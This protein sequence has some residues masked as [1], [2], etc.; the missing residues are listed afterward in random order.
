VIELQ[1]RYENV[2]D[3]VIGRL[4]RSG[5]WTG[6]TRLD[7][8]FMFGALNWSPVVPA[9]RHAR[10]GGDRSRGGERFFLRTPPLRASAAAVRSLQRRRAREARPRQQE[11][12]NDGAAV[13][14]AK[15]G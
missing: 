9:G 11:Q 15:A 10:R 14:P 6:S 2:W 4:Q 12:L 1:K 5:E 7:R 8:L 13:R 3:E